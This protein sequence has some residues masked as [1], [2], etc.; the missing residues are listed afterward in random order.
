MMKDYD[1]V[2]WV[3]LEAVLAKMGFSHAWISMVMRL[4]RTVRFSV[5]LNGCLSDNFL[6]TRGLRQGDPIS[7]YL[8]L[9]CVEGFSALLRQAQRDRQLS[10][11][12][13]GSGGPTITHL[14]FANDSVVFMEATRDSMETLKNILRKYEDSSGQRVNM[15]K[16]S[17]FFGK[18]CSEQKRDELK[19]SIGIECEA[20]SERYLGLPTAVGRAKEGAFKYLTESSRGKVKGWK[21]QGLSKA[22]REV[23]IKSVLQAVSTYA[24]GCFQL[25]KGQCGQLSSVSSQFW[26]SAVDGQ[27]KVH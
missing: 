3:F 5:K 21:G 17:V 10:G 15:Q 4:V 19:S 22:G 14:L 27:W 23:L 24:M 1:R 6:P 20:M 8:F 13:F 2:E 9:F 16:S 11:V 12:S 26:W 25:T 18:G 7:P